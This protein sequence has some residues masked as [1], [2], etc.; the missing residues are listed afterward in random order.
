MKKHQCQ[1]ILFEILKSFSMLDSNL[2]L[3]KAVLELGVTR[4]EKLFSIKYRQYQL[5]AAGQASLSKAEDILIHGQAC[6][7]NLSSHLNSLFSINLQD[8]DDS[9]PSNG[10]QFLL[11]YR[12]ERTK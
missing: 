6:L 9:V 5:T 2:N 8:V 10:A 7:G 11:V 3:S 4:G 12:S 1:S